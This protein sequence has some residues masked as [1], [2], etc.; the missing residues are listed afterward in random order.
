MRLVDV[1]LHLE[2]T[3]AAQKMVDIGD[4]IEKSSKEENDDNWDN[5]HN[6]NI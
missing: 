6:I 3:M 5:E 1:S 2:L 4:D